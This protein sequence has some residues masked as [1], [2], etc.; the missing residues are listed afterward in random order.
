M[1]GR[2]GVKSMAFFQCE[3]RSR[4]KCEAPSYQRFATLYAPPGGGRLKDLVVQPL[5]KIVCSHSLF[6]V[7]NA[8]DNYLIDSKTVDKRGVKG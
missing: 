1:E 8:N 6:F 2:S 5:G 7:Q 3:K 4:K